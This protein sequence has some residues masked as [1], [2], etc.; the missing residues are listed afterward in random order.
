MSEENKNTLPEYAPNQC[1]YCQGRVSVFGENSH[2]DYSAL[3]VIC[4]KCGKHSH[5]VQDEA[6]QCYRQVEQ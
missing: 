1:P 6:S 2:K 3:Q 4:W 5:F